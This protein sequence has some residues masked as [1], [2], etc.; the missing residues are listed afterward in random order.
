MPRTPENIQNQ[1]DKVIGLTEKKLKLLKEMAETIKYEDCVYDLREYPK[2]SSAPRSF[3][4]YHIATGR[5]MKS[6]KVGEMRSYRRIRNI[7]LA[8]IYNGKEL[9]PAGVVEKEVTPELLQ[10]VDLRGMEYKA[11]KNWKSIKEYK[12]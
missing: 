9:I 2:M 5:E 1:L 6:G 8:T 7:D 3:G 4:L 10:V 12:H 11:K